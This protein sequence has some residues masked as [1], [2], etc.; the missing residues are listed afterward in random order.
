MRIVAEDSSVTFCFNT[1]RFSSGA[2]YTLAG[3][4]SMYARVDGNATEITAGFTLTADFDSKTGLNK[5]VLD[6]SADAGYTADS[7][8][9]IFIGAGTVDSVSVADTKVYEF[10]IG[11]TGSQVQANTR[12]MLA[13]PAVAP[14]SSGGLPVIG[15]GT[16]NFKSDG[17]AN[18]TA[19]SV[20][21]NVG[22]N[23]VGSVNGD[24][25]G[26]VL[27]DVFPATG[28]IS[29]NTITSNAFT[30]A[31]FAAD[32]LAA[33]QSECNDALVANNLDHL[34]LLAVTGSD[35][36]D[37]SVIA[38]MVSKSATADWDSFVNTTDALEAISDKVTAA[39]TALD[40]AGV[41]A[42]V[43]LASANLDTQL[44]DIPTV[45]EFNARTLAAASYA[46]EATSQTLLTNLAAVAADLPNRITKN[47]AL[48]GF[49]FLMVNS[50]D[51]VT[52]EPGLTVTAERSIDGGAFGAC[53]NA[54]SEVSAGIYKID[55]AAADLNGNVITLKFTAT[56]ADARFVTIATQPT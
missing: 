53:A 1:K 11:N 43:G 51:H 18:V 17:S 48:A 19:A 27:G 4:P 26:S 10:Q 5:V 29:A 15:T 13:A 8:V 38:K 14:G 33:F 7:L 34:L 24:V 3:T 52:G 9:E 49:T 54:V 40:A 41:R 30:A 44:A 55:L 28:S 25:D 50:T 42:A 46:L 39:G 35:V 16:N 37:N 23:V 12:I 2:P 21:G 56:G 22:G 45:S 32:A 6:L 20:V 36:T 47:T 31:K